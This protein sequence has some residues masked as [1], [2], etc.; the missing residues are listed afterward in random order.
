MHRCFISLALGPLLRYMQRHLRIQ[1]MTRD[2]GLLYGISIKTQ[3]HGQMLVVSIYVPIYTYIL[4]QGRVY[5]QRFAPPR[6]TPQRPVEFFPDHAGLAVLNQISSAPAEKLL[7]N[8]MSGEMGNLFFLA[9]P[10]VSLETGEV[11][12]LLIHLARYIVVFSN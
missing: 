6:L 5:V 7:D 1:T 9:F 8:P 2:T 10:Q 12:R 4:A 3:T 11:T